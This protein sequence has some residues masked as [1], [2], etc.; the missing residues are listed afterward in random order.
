ML[1]QI[2][3]IAQGNPFFALELARHAAAGQP[4]TVTRSV[5]EAVTARFLDLDESTAAMLRRLAVAGDDI[6]TT[7]VLALTGLP[8]PEAFAMLDAGLEAGALTVSGAR[9]RFRHGLVRRALVEQVPRTAGS[10]CTATLPAVWP[11]SMPNQ[12]GSP[13]TGWTGTDRA[14]RRAG[15]SPRP[16]RPSCSARSRTPSASSSRC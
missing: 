14:K 15:C 5:W 4:L 13:G 9:Y 6:D 12:P 7:G 3:E 11:P 2:A 10:P 8:E 1:S 16:A